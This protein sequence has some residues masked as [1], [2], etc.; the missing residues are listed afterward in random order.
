MTTLKSC[1]SSCRYCR[2][3]TPQGLRGGTCELLN[4]SVRSEW[5]ACSLSAPSFASTNQQAVEQLALVTGKA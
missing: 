4:V 2:Y 5:K 1:V 3:Y